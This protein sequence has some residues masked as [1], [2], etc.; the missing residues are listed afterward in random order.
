MGCALGR[1]EP[2]PSPVRVRPYVE[3]AAGLHRDLTRLEEVRQRTAIEVARWG[4]ELVRRGVSLSSDEMFAMASLLPD[5]GGRATARPGR[6]RTQI[7]EQIVAVVVPAVDV[8]VTMQLKFQQSLQYVF[9]NQIQFIVRLCEHSV[10][11]RDGYSQCKLCR[12]RR[13]PHRAVLGTVVDAPVVVLRQVPGGSD[14]AEN[15]VG[16][17]AAVHRRGVDPL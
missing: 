16:A 4:C 13:I 5:F 1:R 3:L 14:S 8:P 15:R 9:V 17:A 11:Q 10:L 7:Q 12:N 2:L 6:N